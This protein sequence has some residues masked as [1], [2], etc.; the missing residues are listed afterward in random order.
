MNYQLSIINYA[1]TAPLGAE[2]ETGQATNDEDG[3][4]LVNGMAGDCLGTCHDFMISWFL[5]LNAWI[6]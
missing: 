4:K 1:G 5:F 3:S 2:T 6:S